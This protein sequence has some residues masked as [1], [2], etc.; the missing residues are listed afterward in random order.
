MNRDLKRK[1]KADASKIAAQ[2]ARTCLDYT[3]N[4][5]VV[6]VQ[7]HR[8]VT[9]LERAF[10][11]MLRGG[12]VPLAMQITPDVA[13]AFPRASDAPGVAKP[14]LA[15]GIDGQGRGTYALRW[16]GIAARN[17]AEERALAELAMLAELSRETGRQGFPMGQAMG[18]A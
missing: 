15:V 11:A 17:E 4:G 6:R 9:V 2:M 10:G 3:G 7:D 13:R 16:L 8:A 12:C 18:R 1:V 14:W 5:V